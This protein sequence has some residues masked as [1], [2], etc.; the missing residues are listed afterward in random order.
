MKQD[1]A[2]GNW[3]MISVGDIRNMNC[4]YILEIS[5]YGVY[6]Y[7]HICYQQLFES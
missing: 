5:D 2:F 7:A 1:G 6:I 3:K 4:S